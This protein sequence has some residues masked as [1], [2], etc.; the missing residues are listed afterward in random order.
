M[1]LDL[2]KLLNRN[3]V[4]VDLGHV[5]D[6]LSNS[7]VLIT[8]AGG[9]IGSELA[10][11]ILQMRPKKLL[12]LDH[13]EFNLYN[14]DLE[15]RE[16][17]SLSEIISILGD[18][19]DKASLQAIFEKFRPQYIYHAAA[20]KHVHLV[21][22][23]P[24]TAIINNVLGTKHLIDC[25]LN[26]G[27]NSFVMV[28]TDKAVNPISV[29]GAT[30]RV[31]EMLITHAAEKSGD[32][33]CSVRF[34]NV[35]GSSGSL[36]P[37]LEK[38][39]LSGGPI[40]ITHPEMMRYF[41]LIEEAVRLVLKAGEISSPGDVNILKMGEPV[42]VV[43]MAKKVLQ[44]FGKSEEDVPIVFTQVR[45]GEKLFEELYLIGDEAPTEHQDILVLPRKNISEESIEVIQRM[46]GLA[47]KK[48]EEAL[49]LLKYLSA[50]E[51]YSLV[52]N[53]RAGNSSV[54]MFRRELQAEG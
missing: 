4:E 16:L 30:K 43:E 51:P 31:C 27:V 18:I 2:H 25:A 34:G 24:F 42:K 3:P 5:E 53:P 41:M 8:G 36:I 21:E 15:L 33:Y 7:V 47:L 26:F 40:T 39:I 52:V 22:R 35:L 20:Y 12:L 19:K 13:S 49:V 32:R 9:S 38:Q 29:M 17:T 1:S 45:P 28:S 44:Q 46:I 6:Q 37:L 11:Q 10:R 14:I 23:N 54:T 50:D 48:D